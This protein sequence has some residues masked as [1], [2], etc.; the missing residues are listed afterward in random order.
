MSQHS[1]QRLVSGDW[2]GC[3]RL[4]SMRG[5]E[6]LLA[7][8]TPKSLPASV[9]SRCSFP[10]RANR[11]CPFPCRPPPFPHPRC[12]SSLT[13]CAR[14]FPP[15]D[16]SALAGTALAQTALFQTAQRCFS[17]PRALCQTFPVAAARP[18]RRAQ[19]PFAPPVGSALPSPRAQTSLALPVRLGLPPVAFP[20][21]SAASSCGCSYLDAVLFPPLPGQ[22]AFAPPARALSKQTPF[23]ARLPQRVRAVP[24]PYPWSGR[25][26]CFLERG[27]MSRR[28]GK[29]KAFCIKKSEQACLSEQPIR[30]EPVRPQHPQT[31]D[32]KRKRRKAPLA[33]ERRRHRT[34]FFA[35]GDSKN[36]AY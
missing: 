36:P 6:L 21:R 27:E 25:R 34:A 8:C 32:R 7:V 9:C 4:F 18:V 1:A 26:A 30:Y 14:F 15:L 11:G 5:R 2:F 31:S 29:E 22:P 35:A 24:F 23:P 33:G 3:A 13:R 10:A 17:S 16:S 12:T 20:A 19:P 28:F